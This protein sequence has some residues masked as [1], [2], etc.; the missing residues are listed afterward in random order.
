M[1]S[2][3]GRKVSAFQYLWC[4]NMISERG[5]KVF[6]LQYLWCKNTSTQSEGEI[7]LCISITEVQ[8][9]EWLMFERKVNVF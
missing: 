6:V 2:E 7:S 1:I 9:Y 8:K 5:R 4:K 3:R